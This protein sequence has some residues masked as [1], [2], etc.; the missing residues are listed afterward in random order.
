MAKKQKLEKI[1]R[2]INYYELNFKFH[3]EFQP[4]DKNHFRELV[5]ILNNLTKT[6]AKIR[7]QTFGEKAIYIRDMSI[8]PTS[9]NITGKLLCV[10][11][12][13][14]PEIMNTTTDESRGLEA[15][16]EEGLVETTHF[17]INFSKKQKTIGIEYNQFGAR[18]GDFVRYLQ[19]IG[20]AK[21][22]VESIGFAPVVNDDLASFSN[23]INRCSEFIVKVHKD[24]IEKIKQLEGHLYTALKSSIEHFESDYATLILKFDY[25]KKEQTKTMTN[26]IYNLI[27][28]LVKDKDKVEFFNELSVRAEDEEKNNLLENFD[29]L[30]DKVKSEIWV[31][32]KERYRSVV[33]VDIFDKIE[34]ELIS[35]NI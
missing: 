35:K 29:L 3:P 15:A 13:L 1:K 20:I 31:E 14:L 25:K 8:H 17:V 30:I 10:R 23:R 28:K 12:D 7:Y 27:T 32:K 22:A 4:Y 33:S 26:T 9:K 24:N 16:E 18:I 5:A 21:N 34:K 19:N 6:K 2:T 11:K